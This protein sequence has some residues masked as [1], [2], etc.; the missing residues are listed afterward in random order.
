MTE[1][2]D[3]GMTQQEFLDQYWQKKPLV[4]RQAFPDFKS[5]ISPNELAGLAGEPRIES[6]LVI[7][8]GA[9]GSWQLID[10]PFSDKDFSVLPKS[11]WTLLVQDIDKHVPETRG[12]LMPFSF[13]PNWRFDDLM[14]SFAPKQ[15]SVGAHTDGYDVFLLQGMGKRKWQASA[16]PLHKPA[17]LENV[18]IQVLADFEPAQ[19]WL[20]EPGDILYLPPHYGHH[21]V[22][23]E[24]CM[25]F[26]IGFRAPNQ[27]ETLDAVINDLVE[28][29]MAKRH[30][31]DSDLQ[32]ARHGYEIGLEA[33]LRLKKLLHETIE[34]AEPLLL[35][36]F[37]KLVTETK[38]SLVSLAEEVYADKPS[39]K[40]LVEQFETGYVLFRN[41]YLRFAWEYHEECGTIYMGGESYPLT[42]CQKKNIIILAEQAVITSTDWQML[43]NDIK[44]VNLLR[45]LVAEGGFYWVKA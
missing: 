5:V 21:G 29:S 14:V 13:I 37:G 30:Y 2:F 31:Q 36:T 26:S 11:H 27:S 20:L 40:M 9:G 38:P 17:L 42:F 28:H 8:K 10:G 33:V 35:A 39:V 6:R 3:T 25:T 32:A 43:S 22:A 16:G 18:D 4:I 1:F 19:E 7:E 44:V 45:S 23:M 34:E 15:G 12:I 24:D 41:P